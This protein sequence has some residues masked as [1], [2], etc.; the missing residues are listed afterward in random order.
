MINVLIVLSWKHM[1]IHKPQ[2]L[3]SSVVLGEV[4]VRWFTL[5]CFAPKLWQLVPHGGSHSR[6]SLAHSPSLLWPPGQHR[7]KEKSVQWGWSCGWRI[8]E[9]QKAVLPDPLEKWQAEGGQAGRSVWGSVGRQGGC[10]SCGTAF[11]KSHW[12]R[13]KAMKHVTHALTW[14]HQPLWSRCRLWW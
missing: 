6:T 9:N 4:L 8:R 7:G 14:Q 2:I 13:S 11:N 5:S 1:T 10:V 3:I 12:P